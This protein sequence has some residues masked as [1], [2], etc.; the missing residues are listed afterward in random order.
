MLTIKKTGAADYGRY[1]KML[2]CAHPG[3][4]KTVF[5][6]TATEPLIVDCESG[7]MSVADKDIAYA[8]V[9]SSLD[10]DQLLLNLQ[11]DANTQKEMMGFCP[12]T[13]VVDTIDEIQR[14]YERERLEQTGQDSLK[15]Q[16]FGW[17]KDRMIDS[18]ILPYRNLDKNVVFLCHVKD[19]QDEETGRTFV[20]PGLKGGIADE[21]AAY[22][23][24][25]A[26]IAIEEYTDVENNESVR[27][28]RHVMQVQPDSRHE[29]LKDRSAKLPP[30]FKLN[31]ETD[32]SKIHKTV[33][34]NLPPLEEVKKEESE[35]VIGTPEGEDLDLP[36]KIV[37]KAEKPADPTKQD[38]SD[39][40]NDKK[41]TES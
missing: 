33:F 32:F 12:Q 31:G 13:I 30:R 38:K 20:K 35:K 21:I 16:D 28:V 23:D 34:K 22:M 3:S 2:V 1:I 26:T 4:G 11:Q 9:K 29:W 39:N 36:D 6:S 5:G 37:R 41:E 24:I 25:V 14:I 8:T 17:L 18:V 15:I 27:K 7:L 19:T 10:N 40:D